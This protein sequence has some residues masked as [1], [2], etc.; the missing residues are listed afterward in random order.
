MENF[1][2]TITMIVLMFLLFCAN[3]L[4][5]YRAYK[6]TNCYPKHT[7]YAIFYEAV[8]NELNFTLFAGRFFI[9]ASMFI[10]A[11]IYLCKNA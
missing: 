7:D 4:Q 3:V 9:P 6:E 2:F 5:K 10:D 11:I 1:R 8:K